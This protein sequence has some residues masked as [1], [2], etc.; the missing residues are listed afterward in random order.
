MIT[1]L[2]VIAVLYYAVGVLVCVATDE[3]VT[4]H[5]ARLALLW[6]LNLAFGFL[7][8]TIYIINEYLIYTTF[9]IFGYHYKETEIY[10]IINDLSKRFY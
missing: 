2:I 5:E 4:P 9:L 6:P 7:M 3:E 8:G 10:R 1:V